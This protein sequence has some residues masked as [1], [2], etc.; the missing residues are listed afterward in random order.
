[1][2][3]KW[4]LNGFLNGRL[5]GSLIVGSLTSTYLHKKRILEIAA[6]AS[7]DNAYGEIDTRK[8]DHKTQSNPATADCLVSRRARY[9]QGKRET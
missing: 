9:K 5:L 6:S 7:T 1:M 2:V 3:F 4:F 8:V